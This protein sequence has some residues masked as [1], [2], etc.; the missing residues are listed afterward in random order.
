MANNINLSKAK[1]PAIKTVADSMSVKCEKPWATY[2]SSSSWRN[3]NST[4]VLNL[5]ESKHYRKDLEALMGACITIQCANWK[6]FQDDNRFD[7]I[8]LLKAEI[9]NFPSGRNYQGSLVIDH[10][11]ASVDKEWKNRNNIKDILR[12]RGIVYAYESRGCK[13]IGIHAVSIKALEKEELIFM[14]ARLISLSTPSAALL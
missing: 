4:T 5:P 12:I 6:I 9:T 14:W 2:T 10:I 3:R 13:N 1:N 8:L 11:W 7:R